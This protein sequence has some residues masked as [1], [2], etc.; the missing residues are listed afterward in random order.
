MLSLNM[1]SVSMICVIKL[2]V[3]MQ[4]AFVQSVDFV[5]LIVVILSLIT[6]SFIIPSVVGVVMRY[7]LCCVFILSAVM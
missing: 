7:S 4:Y 5:M 6:Q 2:S 3:V 1:Q